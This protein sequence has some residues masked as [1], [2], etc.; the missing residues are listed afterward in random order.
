[1]NINPL[2]A[3]S[4]RMLSM[5]GPVCCAIWLSA[6]ALAPQD[7]PP[8]AAAQVAVHGADATAATAVA[9]P[10][11]P[12]AQQRFD[13]AL[14]LLKSGQVS[15]ATQLLQQLAAA[16]PALAGP[17]LNLGLIE[18]KA[19]RYEAA[20]GYFKQAV[21]RDAHSAAASNYL[22]VSYRYLG[23]FKDA[24]SA[25]QAA[26]MVDDSYPA[27]HLN[28]GVLYDLYLQQPDLALP[29]YQRYQSLLETPD[30]KVAGWIKELS[31]RLN[32]DKKSRTTAEVAR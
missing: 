2:A 9:A 24:E 12:E 15:A 30:A 14:D 17:V 7:K 31:G 25:Y 6:C 18:L 4:V 1:M 20:N 10:L 27:A 8:A 16:Y 5:A 3:A 23:R 26:I 22:G 11:P 19:G 28:L 13:Q 21:G 29:Q 32:A